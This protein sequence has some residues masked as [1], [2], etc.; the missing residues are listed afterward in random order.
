MGFHTQWDGLFVHTMRR[1]LTQPTDE[2]RDM[3]AV[4]LALENRFRG[5]AFRRV[6][7]TESHDE[8]ANGKTRLNEAVQPGHAD[9]PIARERS[10]LGAAAIFTAPGLPMIFQ[11]QEFL[12]DKWFDDNR[13]LDWNR[14]KQFDYVLAA[15]HDLIYLRLNKGGNTKGLMG[16]HM[17]IFHVNHEKKVVAYRR[18]ADGGPGDDTIVILN[19]GN[20]AHE[21]YRVGVPNFGTWYVRYNSGWEGYGNDRQ[22]APTVDTSA[23]AIPIDG[24][25]HSCMVAFKP[26]TAIILSQ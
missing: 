15:Y 21:G 22:A 23:D 11:G 26:Y 19:F 25:D 8:V 6:I 18:W 12:E 17:H 16:Q 2:A 5:D 4:C 3:A 7:Y 1:V 9:S 10:I 20:Q 14:A 24:Y 13:P